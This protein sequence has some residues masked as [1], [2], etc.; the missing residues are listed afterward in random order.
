MVPWC[1]L[2]WGV[3]LVSCPIPHFMTGTEW[4]GEYQTWF[5]FL[6]FFFKHTQND[7]TIYI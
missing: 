4:L 1:G 5:Y 6:Y 2:K 7:L 3:S